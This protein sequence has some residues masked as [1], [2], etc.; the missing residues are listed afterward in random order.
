MAELPLEELVSAYFDGELSGD[1]RVRA[2]RLLVEEPRARQLLNEFRALRA[3]VREL[4]RHSLPADFSQQVLKRAERQM[5]AGQPAPVRPTADASTASASQPGQPWSERV[6]RPLIY[7]IL[8]ASIAFALMALDPNQ[9]AQRD[10]VARHQRSDAA[11]RP[12]AEDKAVAT[13]EKLRR[14]TTAPPAPSMAAPRNAAPSIAAPGM[15]SGP[16]ADTVPAVTSGGALPAASSATERLEESP[17]PKEGGLDNNGPALRFGGQAESG[18]GRIDARQGAETQA[19]L[20]AAGLLVVECMVA[21]E[22]LKNEAFQQVLARQQVQWSYAPLPDGEV[23]AAGSRDSI[24]AKQAYE[25]VDASV[26]LLYVEATPEQMEKTLAELSAQP[27]NFPAVA[28]DPVAN[29]GPQQRWQTQ[30]SRRLQRNYFYEQSA[31]Q[32]ARTDTEKADESRDKPLAKAAARL[33]GEPSKKEANGQA[34]PA[35]KPG[36]PPAPPSDAPPAKPTTADDGAK[37]TASRTSTSEAPKAGDAVQQPLP[38]QAPLGNERM[39]N[40]SRARSYS[41]PREINLN[42]PGQ[43]QTP[44]RSGAQEAPPV[45]T[46]PTPA[47]SK[48]PASQSPEPATEKELQSANVSQLGRRGVDANANRLRALFVLQAADVPVGSAQTAP[49]DAGAPPAAPASPSQAKP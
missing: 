43:Q 42:A 32:A 9:R 13:D 6:R 12:A 46:Q 16:L 23:A 5:L 1:E 17:L 14:A 39:N 8:A 21:P 28:V 7:S 26:K 25:A 29:A 45:A 24:R 48:V 22:A 38:Q 33:A 18:S 36:K 31:Q 20:D 35:G 15:A 34:E 11:A 10:Q 41:V 40:L 27:Q 30:Y 4:P 37:S 49:A 44:Q 3:G 19:D 2:E 47:Q